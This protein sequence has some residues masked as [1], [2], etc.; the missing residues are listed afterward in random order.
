MIYLSGG[1]YIPYCVPVPSRVYLLLAWTLRVVRGGVPGVEASQWK[2][3]GDQL[4]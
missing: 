4:L 1:P 3:T 2:V